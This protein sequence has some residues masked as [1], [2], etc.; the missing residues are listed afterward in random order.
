MFVSAVEESA[1][2]NVAGT[3]FSPMFVVS[4]LSLKTAFTT[5]KFFC[6]AGTNP[7]N[8]LLA[9]TFSFKPTTTG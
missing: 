6:S 1:N 3:C 7:S 5:C 8:A 2:V 4:T 9:A